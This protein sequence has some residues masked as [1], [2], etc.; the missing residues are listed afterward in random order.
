MSDFMLMF[1][2]TNYADMGL[3]KEE[4]QQKIGKWWAWQTKLQERGIFKGGSALQSNTRAIKGSDRLVTDQSSAELKEVIG[5]YFLIE[6]EDLET[7]T[8]IAQDYPDF[9]EGGIVEIR[10]LMIYD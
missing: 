2:G 4:L 10:Q 1:K 5:G 8:E 9:D 7:A 6:V 3:S